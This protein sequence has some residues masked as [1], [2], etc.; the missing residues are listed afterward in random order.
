MS[1]TFGPAYAQ[2]YDP[3]YQDKDYGAECDLIGRVFRQY[4]SSPIRSVLDL[5]SGTGNHA[6]PLSRL[7]FHVV[8]VER[9]EAM[10]SVAH[11][12]QNGSLEQAN[13]AF[14]HG[15]IRTVRLG[16]QFD[17]AVMMFAVLGYQLENSDVLS[18]LKTARAH[19]HPGGLLV[20]DVWYGPAVIHQRPSQRVKEISDGRSKILRVA[21]SELDVSR[22]LCRVAFH[23]WSFSGQTTVRETEETHVMRFFFPMELR[24]FVEYA[25]FELTRLGV[26]PD[27][28]QDP[29]LDTWN[30][31]GVCRA[32]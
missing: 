17:A 13:P 18:A 8:G 28:D 29:A 16:R 3:L 14:R 20:F 19:L 4:A 31:L 27:F 26:F 2:A 25:G 22:H 6:F 9:S 30:I 23:M 1:Q 15:D 24:L 32:T 7:G 12:K 5:G 10:L 21:T 11:A